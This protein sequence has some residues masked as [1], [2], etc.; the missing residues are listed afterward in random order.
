MTAEPAD[1]VQDYYRRGGE[2]SRLEDGLGLVEFER[3]REILLRRLPP[4]PAV[5]ADIGGGP[6]RYALWL[7]GLGY[8]VRLRDIVPLHIEQAVLS[9]EAASLTV[10]AAVGDARDLDLADGS[11]DAVLLLGPLYHLTD[12]ADRNRCLEEA[13]RVLRPGGVLFVAAFSRWAARLQ[14]E[15]VRTLYRSL[16][17]LRA[18]VPGVEATGVMPPLF[19][20]SFLAYCHR[21][22]ELREEVEAAGLECLDLV[23]VEGIA[24]ALSDLDERLRTPQDRDVV[25]DAARALERVPELLGIGPHLVATARRI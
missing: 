17:N 14:A 25:F 7:A 1:A 6:G 10:D 3:T 4:P 8:T 5:V 21:P 24:F 15:V 9:A 13:C 20:G 19:K 11:V 2:Q 16:D 22:D 23:S 18:A 12:P